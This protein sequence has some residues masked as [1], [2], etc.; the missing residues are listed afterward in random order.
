MTTFLKTER[1]IQATISPYAPTNTSVLSYQDVKDA[2]GEGW[3]ALHPGT[4]LEVGNAQE[5]K[6]FQ[7]NHK[8]LL[9]STYRDKMMEGLGAL[10][11]AEFSYY[12][13]DGNGGHNGFNAYP[14]E[15]IRSINQSENA[16]GDV[17]HYSTPDIYPRNVFYWYHSSGDPHGISWFRDARQKELVVTEDTRSAPFVCAGFSHDPR[18]NIRPGQW[19]GMLK[20]MSAAG[21]EYFN[22]G[23]FIP[24]GYNQNN[25]QNPEHWA[26][27]SAMP[28]YAQGTM[29]LVDDIILEG[30][31]VEGDD[32]K[33]VFVADG[34]F[35]VVTA[36]RTHAS[37]NR[38]LISSSLGRNTNLFG[39]D[40]YG[41]LLTPTA[42]S[43]DIT[44]DGSL[45]GLSGDLQLQARPQGSTYVLEVVAGSVASLI[46]LDG[47]HENKHPDFWSEDFVF[48][49]EVGQSTDINISVP[50]QGL[51]TGLD[52]RTF[53][54]SVASGTVQ[55]PFQVRVNQSIDITENGDFDIWLRLKSASADQSL[56]LRILEG[57]AT[58]VIQT[59]DLSLCQ[60]VSD[61]TWIHPDLLSIMN[62]LDGNY[63]LELELDDTSDIEVDQLVMD[64]VHDLDDGLHSSWTPNEP[65][66]IDCGTDGLLAENQW[67]LTQT[68]PCGSNAYKFEIVDLIGNGPEES[69]IWSLNG[70]PILGSG[71]ELEIERKSLSIPNGELNIAAQ[72][73]DD[74]LLLNFLHVAEL[75]NVQLERSGGGHLTSS[76][77][78]YGELESTAFGL[79][80]ITE[81]TD[82]SFASEFHLTSGAMLAKAV[83]TNERGLEIAATFDPTGLAPRTYKVGGFGKL[84]D[85][86]PFSMEA[87]EIVVESSGTLRFDFD[88]NGCYHIDGATGAQ[89]IQ[90]PQ[91][92]QDNLTFEV[93]S[94]GG[95][96]RNV[97][98]FPEVDEH[99]SGHFTV[100]QGTTMLLEAWAELEDGSSSYGTILVHPMS[101]TSNPCELD[102]HET[103]S[104]QND[105]ETEMEVLDVRLHVY[106]NP[107]T[108]E[109]TVEMDGMESGDA[110][111]RVVNSLG[112][113]V[114]EARAA[115]VRT[116][117]DIGHL[118]P[119]VYY[120]VVERK[121]E[122]LVKRV[123]LQ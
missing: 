91:G 90:F 111:L 76:G 7:A 61:F 16:M 113:K 6:D 108:G 106:P 85:G 27:Q 17:V 99:E 8:T 34:R 13:V 81:N 52:Y 65:I 35:D 89:S 40:A 14:W 116:V 9:R 15:Y 30:D 50:D 80:Q 49:A 71:F 38:Y 77:C 54:T 23:Y 33:W 73:G 26:W 83:E 67:N 94:P 82:L 66:G 104:S 24:L 53:T 11:N 121:G 101:D 63:F 31:Y 79:V 62:L 78:S 22:T 56:T 69:V 47:W 86:C 5:W 68:N 88:E 51:N 25:W 1:F 28:G 48:E 95:T 21:A 44:L 122:Q 118:S 42:E 74:R 110:L 120:L 37:T 92:G 46:Q 70:A 10:E 43:V 36:V 114:H 87:A 72:V 97:R 4:D 55:Y 107:N 58:S 103:G 75:S 12:S 96:I 19:L 3:F 60:S 102:L 100:P 39:E 117:L 109:F 93:R 41:N 119:G 115:G 59:F 98:F 20:V 57:D 112:Q 45:F 32:S 64:F 123:V 2:I 29:S 84:T 18:G 105:P